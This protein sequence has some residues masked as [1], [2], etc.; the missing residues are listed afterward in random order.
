MMKADILEIYFSENDN[1][2]ETEAIF[3]GWRGDII[4]KIGDLL[5]KIQVITP[6]RLL[7]DFNSILDSGKAPMF[8]QPLILVHKTD[9]ASIINIIIKLCETDFFSNIQAI[10]LKK[11]FKN[12][13]VELQSIDNWCKVL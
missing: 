9:T 13:F 7:V 6:D 5:Y 2:S 10:E 3:R 11:E 12:T 4:V 1:L 8:N